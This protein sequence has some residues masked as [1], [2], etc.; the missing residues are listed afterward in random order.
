MSFRISASQSVG[1]GLGDIRSLSA[2]NSILK[3]S[4]RVPV[5]LSLILILLLRAEWLRNGWWQQARVPFCKTSRV[6]IS[7]RVQSLGH[8]YYRFYTNSLDFRGSRVQ[9]QGPNFLTGGV[10]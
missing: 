1:V 10:V 7:G 6:G 8:S 5:S 2:Q 3:I 4:L 9:K